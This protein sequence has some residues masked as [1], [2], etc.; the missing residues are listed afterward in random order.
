EFMKPKH[1]RRSQS[2]PNPSWR[3][4]PEAPKSNASN[5]SGSIKSSAA[6]AM[7][8]LNP[9]TKARVVPSSRSLP[10]QQ[11]QQVSSNKRKPE[12]DLNSKP[13]KP[14]IVRQNASN[15]SGLSPGNSSPVSHGNKQHQQVQHGQH[16]SQPS[17]GSH[18]KKGNGG[19]PPSFDNRRARDNNGRINFLKR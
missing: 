2:I 8:T 12:Q 15:T 3:H 6:I 9:S 19:F 18:G 17:Q 4:L 11:K 10:S 5:V 14:K 13:K 7:S 16:S 1:L